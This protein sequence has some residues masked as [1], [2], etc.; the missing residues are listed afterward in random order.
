MIGEPRIEDRP[1]QPCAGIRTGV[2]MHELP[3]VIPQLH[4][5]VFG[6]LAQHGVSPAGAPFIR[7][8][9]IDMPSTLD[10]EMGWPLANAVSSDG[11]IAAGILPAGQYAVLLY[12]G[13][14]DGLMQANKALLDWGKAR[15]LAL[16]QR[17][18]PTGDA[19]GARYESYLTDPAEEPDPA[20]WETEVAIRLA[21]A[22]PSR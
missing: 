7:Y 11:R 12:T 21:D 20:K 5:E 9:T 10:V 18:S 19:F 17:A 2:P 15:G 14:Y 1:D 8:H 13:P 6:W 3:T 4:R 22:Q 16:D